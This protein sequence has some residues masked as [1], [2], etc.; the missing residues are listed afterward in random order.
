MGEIN[1]INDYVQSSKTIC[2]CTTSAVLL[3]LL[4]IISPLKNFIF[5]SIVGRVAILAILG[6]AILRNSQITYGLYN[7]TSSNVPKGTN[8]ICSGFFSIFIIILFLSVLKTFFS[9]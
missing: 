7:I 9:R 5:S 8:L 1:S 4:F 6:Y 3:I 2:L